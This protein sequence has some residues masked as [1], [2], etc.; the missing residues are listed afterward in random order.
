M[1]GHLNSS[2]THGHLTG[3]LPLPPVTCHAQFSSQRSTINQHLKRSGTLTV[4]PRSRPI[5]SAHIKM[6]ATALGKRHTGHRILN[7]TPQAVRHQIRRLDLLE[8]LV[9]SNPAALIRE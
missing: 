1:Q 8:C 9:V 3:I 5:I 2:L 7:G 4:I 6:I